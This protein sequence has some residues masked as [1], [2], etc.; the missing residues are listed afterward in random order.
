MTFVLCK[1]ISCVGPNLLQFTTSNNMPID[2]TWNQILL[3]ALNGLNLKR[4]FFFFLLWQ[5]CD[6]EGVAP[7]RKLYGGDC[8]HAHV[9]NSSVFMSCCPCCIF[10]CC[11][12]RYY[13]CSAPLKSLYCYNLL[14]LPPCRSN[15][16][17]FGVRMGGGPDIVWEQ[18]W[19]NSVVPN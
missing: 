1:W 14:I 13:H 17:C 15:S 4:A 8:V 2:S 18:R 11:R 9:Y 6:I 12:S 19:L 7:W 5:A 3:A 10:T 16:S